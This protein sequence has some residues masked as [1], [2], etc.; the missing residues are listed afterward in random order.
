M[1]IIFYIF[2]YF[3]YIINIL[4]N[5]NFILDLIELT[6]MYLINTIGDITVVNKNRN[7]DITKFN[8]I[9]TFIII[10]LFLDD[11]FTKFILN[12][13]TNIYIMIFSIL[14]KRLIK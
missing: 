14:I 5:I 4:F 7:L 10:Y 6:R 12:N 9:N 11:P 3:T 2:N 1:N 8:S 13:I